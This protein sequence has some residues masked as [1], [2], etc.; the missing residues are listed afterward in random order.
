LKTESG[1]STVELALGLPIVLLLIAIVVE[2][3]ALA[4]DNTRLWHAAREAARIAVVDADQEQIQAAAARTA[5]KP[6][7]LEIDPEPGVRRQ[8]DPLTVRL[9][10]QPHG[11]VPIL[12]VLF[13]Q[14]ELVATAS[15]RIEQP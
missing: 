15:M 4:V 6:F 11:H 3:A 1:Q 10:H 7:D 12:G 13:G 9:R 8:G 2:V 14:L 5:P